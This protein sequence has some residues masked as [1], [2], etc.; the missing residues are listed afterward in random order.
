MS[1]H[2]LVV[3]HSGRSVFD[4][5]TGERVARDHGALDDAWLV[6]SELRAMG[7]GPI[8]NEWVPIAGIWGGGLPR[9]TSDSW[10]VTITA[11]DWPSEQI[12]LEPP[13]RS[14]LAEELSEGCVVLDRPIN[15]LRA[16]GFTWSGHT[17]IEAT[18]ADIRMW[19]R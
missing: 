14:V 4:P 17:L 10:G 5:R 6:E 1:D 8:E 7:M 2:V 9:M 18:S 13:G 15:E 12:V 11:A 16:V 19:A 3:S